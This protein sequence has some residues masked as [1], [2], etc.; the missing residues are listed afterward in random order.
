V[1][2]AHQEL[3]APTDPDWLRDCGCRFVC[4]QGVDLLP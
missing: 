3:V 4:A 2:P 1:L